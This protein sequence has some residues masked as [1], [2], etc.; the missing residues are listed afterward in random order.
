[1]P[2]VPTATTNQIK[3]MSKIRWVDPNFE[4][5]KEYAERI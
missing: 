2:N 3:G 4:E 1:M 5:K